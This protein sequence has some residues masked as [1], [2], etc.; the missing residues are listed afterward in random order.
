[1]KYFFYAETPRQAC[2]RVCLPGVKEHFESG[3]NAVP[4]SAA[5]L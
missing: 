4:P 3:F 1:M 5:I 2:L